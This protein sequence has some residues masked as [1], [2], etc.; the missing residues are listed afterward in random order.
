MSFASGHSPV[1]DVKHIKN[2]VGMISPEY[3]SALTGRLLS[4]RS[5]A[6][7][8]H[9]NIFGKSVEVSS[10]P[11][12]VYGV[13]NSAN[14][15][16][17]YF[18]GQVKEDFMLISDMPEFAS[19]FLHMLI[20]QL[21][22]LI[23]ET[24]PELQ[25]LV[26]FVEKMNHMLLTFGDN[27]GKAIPPHNDK[28][29]SSFTSVGNH[30]SGT[31]IILLNF[32]A[33]RKFMLS[34][35][36]ASSR[37]GVHDT[38]EKMI[39]DGVFIKAFNFEGGDLIFLPGHVNAA[40][41]HSIEIN[42][43]I[44]DPRVS[45][46]LRLVDADSVNPAQNYY[47]RSG[48]RFDGGSDWPRQPPLPYELCVPLIPALVDLEEDYSSIDGFESPQH[49]LA[50]LHAKSICE[51]NAMGQEDF[52]VGKSRC[53]QDETDDMTGWDFD[54][55]TSREVGVARFISGCYIGNF[56]SPYWGAAGRR[57]LV[58]G[59]AA[60]HS[61]KPD[62]SS[63]SAGQAST[64]VVDMEI[65]PVPRSEASPT[66]EKPKPVLHDLK[67]F[68]A[69]TFYEIF[70]VQPS[71]SAN[72]IK[73]A[74]NALALNYHPDKGGDVEVFK[75]IVMAYG[76]L[77]NKKTRSQYD[78]H[79]KAKF[80]TGFG[81]DV[82]SSSSSSSTLDKLIYV[83]EPVDTSSSDLMDILSRKAAGLVQV[84]YGWHEDKADVGTLR[85]LFKEFK[86]RSGSDGRIPVVWRRD[87]LHKY[88]QQPG[89]YYSGIHFTPSD[90]PEDFAARVQSAMDS[91]PCP[92]LYDCT[93]SVFDKV[94]K[95]VKE[96]FRVGL[97][98]LDPDQP[99]CFPRAMIS[100]HSWSVYLKQWC[101]DCFCYVITEQHDPFNP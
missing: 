96:V 39:A 40:Y 31:P 80:T 77:L 38:E 83:L 17:L 24:M 41:K 92:N 30:E 57:S 99:K 76:V 11:K 91:S 53:I 2:F 10:R 86:A 50:K 19:E 97:N 69:L 52:D 73:K 47:V 23:N 32:G 89:R 15:F 22:Q 29:Y 7:T 79:G 60:M 6:M 1:N 82:P 45:M 93:V 67:Y 26:P 62:A 63:S 98:I 3:L 33:A 87:Q 64:V 44:T 48:V 34:T 49:L 90:M 21:V 78:A 43:A 12:Q 42:H 58:D 56:I 71:A 25:H 28:T 14:E 70:G 72:A 74:Y 84:K 4:I 61:R 5:E 13:R 100:R 59:L 55:G 75:Y 9:F 88:I 37:A 95:L 94:P 85:A 18:W 51:I 54:I 46:V 68:M 35:N 66:A 65:E 16:G 27:G 36:A 81:S 101:E 8:H 20:K